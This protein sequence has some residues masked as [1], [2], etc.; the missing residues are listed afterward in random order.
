LNSEHFIKKDDLKQIPDN[1]LKKESERRDLVC[2][3]DLGMRVR[4]ILILLTFGLNND[5]ASSD[6]KVEDARGETAF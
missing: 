5:A 2:K 1:F 3:R 4:S 6:Q